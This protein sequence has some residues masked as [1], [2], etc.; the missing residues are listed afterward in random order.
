M[1]DCPKC[2]AL[3]GSV[4]SVVGI[5]KVTNHRCSCGKA[6]RSKSLVGEF[7]ISIAMQELSRL[8]ATPPTKRHFLSSCAISYLEFKVQKYNDSALS[9]DAHLKRVRDSLWE[10]NYLKGLLGEDL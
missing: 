9:H 10:K 6:W 2:G 1:A 5:V 7:Q 4:S 8:K 3:V